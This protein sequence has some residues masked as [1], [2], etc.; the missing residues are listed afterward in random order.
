MNDQTDIFH[1]VYV[2]EAM[3]SIQEAQ[4]V[5]QDIIELSVSRNASLGITGALI[6]T[7]NR[8]SQLLEGPKAAVV[9]LKASILADR[10]H[11][12]VTTLPLA[13]GPDR[14]F[15]AWSLAYYGPSRFL[16]RL[17]EGVQLQQQQHSK[18]VCMDIA[19]MFMEFSNGSPAD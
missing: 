8:F 11:A 3:F 5:I 19:R 9:D 16:G 13:L 10:R 17:L 2:S 6:F 12:K 18:A 15:Q 7:G 14:M 4:R 1:W